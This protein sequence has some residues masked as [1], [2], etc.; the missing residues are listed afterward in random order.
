VAGWLAGWLVALRQ[1]AQRKVGV[2]DMKCRQDDEIKQVHETNKRMH[3]MDTHKHNATPTPPRQ[4][5]SKR[6]EKLPSEH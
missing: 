5:T 1:P 4:K 2:S 3:N 6:K